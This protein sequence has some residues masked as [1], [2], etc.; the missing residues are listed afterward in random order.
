MQPYGVYIKTDTESRLVDINSSAF[1]DDVSSWIKID[2]GFGDRFYHA[3]SNYLPKPKMDER[4]R[5]RYKYENDKVQ[6]RTAAEMD[7]DVPEQGE[8][9]PTLERRVET[10][11]EANAELIEA[12]DMI[13]S[14]VTE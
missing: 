1:L 8:A 6:E 5:C 9:R 10:L 12:V 2:E 11:E 14:G 7:A 4:G 3:Q 13:L